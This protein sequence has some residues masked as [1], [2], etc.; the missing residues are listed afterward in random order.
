MPEQDANVREVIFHSIKLLTRWTIV[1]FISVVLVAGLGFYDSIQQ[2]NQITRVAVSN[3]NALCA[4]RLDVQKRYE[5]GIDFLIKHPEGIEGVSNETI[6][7]G[8]ESQKATLD[9]LSNLECPDAS[10]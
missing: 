9:A 8:L 3:N 4:L 1:M 2:R 10:S 6:A 7:R 5:N